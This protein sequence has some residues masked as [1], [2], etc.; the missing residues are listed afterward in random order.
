[1]G[2]LQV[3]IQPQR[4]TVNF[5]FFPDA[6]VN[7]FFL[8]VQLQSKLL[9]QPS[10]SLMP[11]S[12]TEKLMGTLLWFV[13]GICYFIIVCV[14]TVHISTLHHLVNNLSHHRTRLTDV[15]TSRDR[16][17]AVGGLQGSQD[18]VWSRGQ[19]PCLV[20]VRSLVRIWA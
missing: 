1:M 5:F 6:S 11:E 19:Q 10:S 3:K 18:L 14:I 12:T 8:D 17:R 15:D 7:F 9:H 4:P 20:T 16:N 2:E 13:Q